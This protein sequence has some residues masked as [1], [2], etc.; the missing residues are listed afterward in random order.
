MLSFIPAS[1]D[2]EMTTMFASVVVIGT[3]WWGVIEN[4]DSLP[5][6]ILET[7]QNETED[8]H[9]PVKPDGINPIIEQ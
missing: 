6:P 3:A 8:Q 2:L 4:I 1:N 9:L 7:C 5:I